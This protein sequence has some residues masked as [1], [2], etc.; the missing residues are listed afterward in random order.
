[1]IIH[2]STLGLATSY[3]VPGYAVRGLRISAQKRFETIIIK[4]KT[5]ASTCTQSAEPIS[6]VYEYSQY[7][8]NLFLTLVEGT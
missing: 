1:M 7:I 4:K 8:F 6:D 5:N 2:F 3:P